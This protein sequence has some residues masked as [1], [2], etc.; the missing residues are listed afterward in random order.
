M[1]L[2]EY[3]AALRQEGLAPEGIAQIVKIYIEGRKAGKD[4]T[5]IRADMAAYLDGVL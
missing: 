4:D 3:Y 1:T 2:Q 5:A